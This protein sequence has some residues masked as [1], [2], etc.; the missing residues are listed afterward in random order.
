MESIHCCQVKVF[1][2]YEIFYV[3]QKSNTYMF[4]IV[5]RPTVIL[6][7]SYLTEFG[8]AQTQTLKTQIKN[9]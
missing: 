1:V 5:H 3:R 9:I 4:L 2:D 8:S 7:K 6:F